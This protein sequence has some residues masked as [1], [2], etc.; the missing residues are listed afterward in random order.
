MHHLSIDLETYSSV[1]IAKAGAQKYISNPDFEILL[2]AYSVDGAPVEIIDLARGERL[3]PWLVQA[4]T[5]P[6]YI[7]HAYNAPFEWGCLSKF[8]GTL[9]PDQW[10]CTMFHGLYCG[11]T[12]GLDAT[13]KALGLAE[14]KR[15]L[16]TGK[17]LIRYFCVPCAPTKA[18]GGRTRNLPQHDTD[19][20]E[21]FKEYCRQ[22]VVTEMEIERRLSAFPVPGFVQKQWET[23]LI[24]NARG[25]AVDMDLVSGALYLGNVTRQNLT[26]EA[27]KISKLDNPNSVAQLTQW[28]QEAMG[29]ELADLR[30]DTVARLLGKED[31]SPQVQR[32]LEIRQELGKTSTKK[33]DAKV[34]EGNMSDAVGYRKLAVNGRYIRGFGVPKYASK[35]TSAPSGGGEASTPGKD[36]KPAPGLA[37]G[38]V[39][40]FTG[41]KHYISSMAVNGK[42]CKPGEAKVTAVA[43]SGKHPY[44]LIKTTGSSS[45]VYGWVDAADVKEA[46][47]AIVKGSRVKVAKGA[48]TYNGGSLASYVYTTTYTVIQI[49]GS[50]VVIGINGVVTAAVNIKDLTLVG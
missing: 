40:T 26:Q 31:N 34:I 41:T 22:D 49:D 29:E 44:H 11:Y 10:R 39:V 5:S 38:S 50:R 1:P 2:F 47:P 45:T 18:N 14:D 24:I 12:A 15:K 20:W 7:K 23:D 13:G 4:I 19:K 43:K 30:K 25:V 16:N 46:V 8:L 37:V 6:E 33:Y 17:A 42:S 3:P 48:K 28:L 36:E 21:L 35:A 32:M 9:P 27:M